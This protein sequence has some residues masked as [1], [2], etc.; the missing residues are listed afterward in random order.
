MR[1]LNHFGSGPLSAVSRPKA[2]TVA[3]DSVA[4]HARMRRAIL[5]TESLFAIRPRFQFQVDIRIR[6]FIIGGAVADDEEGGI[7]VREIQEVMSVAG[8]SRKANACARPDGLATCVRH[9]R[10]FTLNHIDELIL[11]RVRVTGRRLTA[12]L[13][14]NEIH[15]VILQPRIVPQAP[16]VPL[17]LPLPER[18]RIARCV[19]LGHI[20][21]FEYFRSP[22]HS[23]L[24]PQIPERLHP[25]SAASKIAPPRATVHTLPAVG[26]HCEARA[27][28]HDF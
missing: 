6:H 27:A 24:P 26:G 4:G 17:T 20:A 16:I 13:D 10:E 28:R 9:E 8:A 21:W 5:V 15:S 2:P 19:A 18:L 1:T 3:R 25:L 11:L 7:L 14:P 22:C 23:R 12:G